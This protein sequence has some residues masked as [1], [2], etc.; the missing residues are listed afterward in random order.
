MKN[1]LIILTF[2]FLSCSGVKYTYDKDTD[3]SKYKTFVYTKKGMSQAKLSPVYKKIIAE[4]IHAYIIREGLSPASAHPDMVIDI[5]PDFHKR[6]DVY[7]SPYGKRILKSK[8]GTLT[9]RFS[10]ADT[11]R[12]VWEAKTYLKF[13]NKKELRQRLQKKLEKIFAHYPPQN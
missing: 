10:D 3:F 13:K 12:V 11:H 6:I 5:I 2:L 1:L 7:P 4:S 9:I 8:E